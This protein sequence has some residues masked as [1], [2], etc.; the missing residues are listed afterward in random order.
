LLTRIA[1]AKNRDLTLVGLGGGLVVAVLLLAQPYMGLRHDAIL[2]LGQVLRALSPAAMRG[3]LFF[4]FG[5]QDELSIYSRLMAPL[6]RHWSIEAVQLA[7]IIPCQFL[8]FSALYKALR[9]V[10]Q[11]AL[12]WLGLVA[13]AGLPREYGGLGTFAFSENFLTARTLAEPLV[14]WAL[15]AVMYRR[16]LIGLFLMGVAAACHPL[17]ALPAMLMTGLLLAKR[18]RRWYWVGGLLLLLP[19]ILAILGQRPFAALLKSYD[20]PWWHLITEVNEQVLLSRWRWADWQII[21]MDAGLLCLGSRLLPVPLAQLCRACGLALLILLAAAFIGADLL[22]NQL[23][24]Q[25]QLWRVHWVA[26]AL[27]LACMPALAMTLW[28]SV[29]EAQLR[30]MVASVAVCAVL[31]TYSGWDTAWLIW[32]SC[33]TITLMA[34]RSRVSRG[35]AVLTCAGGALGIVALAV[36]GVVQQGGVWHSS[37]AHIPQRPFWAQVLSQPAVLF[38][39]AAVCLAS[40]RRERCRV[41]S[42]ILAALLLIVALSQADRRSDWTRLLETRLYGEPHPFLHL[43]EPYAQVYWH[44]EL[45]PTWV[46]LRHP[47]YYAKPQGAGLLFNEG[48][49]REFGIRRDAWATIRRDV[50]SCRIGSALAREPQSNCITPAIDQVQ[51]LCRSQVGL[52]YLVFERVLG[53]PPLATW[54]PRLASFPDQEF[55]LYACKQLV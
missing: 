45:A 28:S 1:T 55:H 52:D 5:S 49:A 43:M 50:V 36:A 27:A 48:T 16:E 35:L 2:Y 6:Y 17:M 54:R 40:W 19:L 47:S 34:R 11:P 10:P 15:V 12:R 4:A 24:T 39:F 18:D 7:F 33:A 32:V 8:S 14:L 31:A 53:V 41:P 13:V 46:L 51:A 26:H 37:Y 20:E 23:L 30:W 21:A 44:E 9:D 38:V 3:D 29:R 25:L 42:V 22:R